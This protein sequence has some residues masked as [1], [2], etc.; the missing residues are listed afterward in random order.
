MTPKIPRH[1]SRCVAKEVGGGVT[2]LLPGR[3]GSLRWKQF[4]VKKSPVWFSGPH[5]INMCGSV[6]RLIICGVL[7][8]TGFRFMRSG[9]WSASLI[10]GIKKGD[11]RLF[12]KSIE[13]F[14]HLSM[15]ET[16][17]KLWKWVR[18]RWE[19][20]EVG[21]ESIFSETEYLTDSGLTLFTQIL[22]LA[23]WWEGIFLKHT[24]MFSRV[25]NLLKMQVLSDYD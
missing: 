8:T 3:S 16:T 2:V 18:R 4:V 12:R 25:G 1:Q 13:T 15:S 17:M 10:S 6:V 22:H 24:C 20:D 21:V 9:E 23:H 5:P 14:V 19:P 11:N 7:Y